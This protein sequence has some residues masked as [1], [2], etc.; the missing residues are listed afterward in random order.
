MKKE[1][2]S[3]KQD[4]FNREDSGIRQ[5]RTSSPFAR[6]KRPRIK[7]VES[8][9]T[10]DR[11]E[12]GES[13]PRRDNP[14]PFSAERK[15]F[16]PNFDSENRRKD[17]QKSPFKE[18][19]GD[20][21]RRSYSDDAY[22]PRSNSD[23][24]RTQNRDGQSSQHHDNKHSQS[25]QN[26][27]GQPSEGRYGQSAEGRPRYNSA[28]GN[29][30]KKDFRNRPQGGKP[31][32]KPKGKK[33]RRQTP[34][35]GFD[36]T[37]KPE[38]YPT[39]DAAPIREPLRLNRYISMS[40]ICSRRDADEFIK[41]GLVSVNGKLVTELG[42]KIKPTD[43]VRYNGQVI[44]GEKNVYILMNKPKGFV[45]TIDDPNAERTV[46]DI[47]KNACSERVYPVGRLDK[48]SL[49]V[50]LITNDGDLTK[51][52]T[53]PSFNKKKVYQ[54]TLDKSIS[55]ADLQKLCEGVELDDG[56]A[57]FDEANYVTATKKE[58][59]VVI[60]S[61]RNRVVRRMFE[62]LGYNVNKLDRVYFSG[63]TKKGLRRGAW[64]YL[65]PQEVIM[66]KSGKFD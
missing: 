4:F 7:R 2:D 45:T 28:G 50:L 65:T 63:L 8:T 1:F 19:A 6:D 40:G 38:T 58:I 13:K 12:P 54:V 37:Y 46:M 47:V 5:E 39:F 49:G 23:R 16:N 20:E 41:Q 62:A 31:G 48:N 29:N 52:L 33:M 10:A 30:N 56:K 61:G 27:Y 17:G 15:S 24:L 36:S 22:K 55:A 32:F 14:S 9:A 18:Y 59:G 11:R 51:R 26:R 53:H 44:R 35:G 21:N 60:H 25:R 57:F 42:V 64:R 66:L 43:E 34:Q 3:E